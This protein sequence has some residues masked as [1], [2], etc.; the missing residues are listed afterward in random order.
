MDSCPACRKPLEVIPFPALGR[1]SVAGAVA[2]AAVSPDDAT[3]FFHASKRAVV[4]CDGCGRF[5]CAL[6]DLPIHGIHLCPPCLEAGR[7]KRTVASM[8]RSR[9]R[10]DLVATSLAILC[11]LCGVV[12][13]IAALSNIAITVVTWRKPQSRVASSRTALLVAT[14]F[15]IL[16]AVGLS[17]VLWLEW[18]SDGK[19]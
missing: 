16:V 14:T 12:S 1:P 18:N 6:C 19:T 15:S 5:L 2:E 3:C 9:T 10:W 11:L 8:Q 13:P 4:P 7:Q 17:V